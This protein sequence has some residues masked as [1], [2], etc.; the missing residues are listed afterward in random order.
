MKKNRSH[1][2]KGRQGPTGAVG[3]RGRQGKRG[4]RG[5]AGAQGLRGQKGPRGVKGLPGRRGKIGATGTRGEQ[6]LDGSAPVREM[7]AAVEERFTDVYHQLDLQLRRMAQLQ[8]ELDELKVQV[9]G[10]RTASSGSP[11][12]ERMP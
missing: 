6:G 5:K 9:R 11:H 2:R 7:V 4:P 1:E 8:Q 3:T 12:T 10:T